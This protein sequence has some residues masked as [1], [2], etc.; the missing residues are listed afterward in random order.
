M[1]GMKN[2]FYALLP[3]KLVRKF[4]FKK[5]KELE[6]SFN[7]FNSYLDKIIDE[8]KKDVVSLAQL[9][10]EAANEDKEKKLPKEAVRDNILVFFIAGH[11]TTSTTLH[12]IIYNMALYPEIQDK[13]RAEI[14]NTFP[15][16]VDYEDPE[17]SE[18]IKDMKYL[19]NIINE[20]LRLFPPAGQMGRKAESD[21]VLGDWFIPKDTTLQ[22]FSYSLQRDKET[23][24]EDA[25]VY[26]PDRFDNFTKEQKLSFLPF[27][28]GPRACIG[29]MFSLLE[30]KIF[31]IK[32]FKKYKISLASG[33]KLV[34]TNLL[35]APKSELL[36]FIFEKID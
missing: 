30:Q 7:E 5:G 33:S 24:G 27:G 23:W 9:L 20:T 28:S 32:L 22:V 2:P 29:M 3:A 4:P 26:N 34:P 36:K 35:Y 17:S 1:E 31:T 15:H 8:N 12:Y 13:L 21:I 16:G 11:E 10:I 19:G 25:E 18:K 14:N 6:K